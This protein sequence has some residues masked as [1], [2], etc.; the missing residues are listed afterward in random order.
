MI[1]QTT[2]HG[3]NPKTYYN[4]VKVKEDRNQIGLDKLYT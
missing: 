1:N 2:T 4:P 3:L